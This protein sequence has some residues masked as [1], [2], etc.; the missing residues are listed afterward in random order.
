MLHGSGLDSSK[1]P[2][3]KR[4]RPSAKLYCKKVVSI[5]YY[6]IKYRFSYLNIRLTALTSILFSPFALCFQTTREF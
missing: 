2:K 6:I 4:L 3:L 5:F 1:A